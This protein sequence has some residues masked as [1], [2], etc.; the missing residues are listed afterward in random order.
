MHVGY[1]RVSSSSQETHL[2]LDA[3]RSAG[4]RRI[5]SEKRSAV[6]HRPQLSAALNALAPGDVLHVYKV[7]RVARSMRH[8]VEILD[9][10]H[11]SGA[12]FRSLTEPID[13][14]TPLGEFVLHILGAV[15]QF[16][17]Q[18]IKERA[19]AGQV[20]AWRR[21]V[22]WGGQRA[23]IG[24]ADKAELFRLRDTGL[25]TI[26]LLAEIF[27]CSVATVDRAL[28]RRRNP[29]RYALRRLPVLGQHL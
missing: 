26:P 22:R 19:I 14:S 7:D 27:D 4:V 9:V 16:E 29:E 21:G 6:A 24:D 17:R 1:V 28:A 10:V 18:L 8:L 11:A 23:A 20:A 3:L 13:T 5:F 12:R 2:Q 15:A 25:F